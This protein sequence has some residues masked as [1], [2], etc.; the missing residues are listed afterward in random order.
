MKYEARL[1][2]L[3]EVVH[4]AALDSAALKAIPEQLAQLVGGMSCIVLDQSASG[5]AEALAYNVFAAE[6]EQTYLSQF[7]ADDPWTLI[8]TRHGIG[9]AVS[10]DRHLPLQEFERTRIYNEFARP[11]RLEPT[12]C[13]SVVLPAP[14]GT[15]I[16]GIQRNRRQ[17][18][19]G[20]EHEAMLNRLLPHFSHLLELR[21]RLAGA[22]AR[23]RMAEH[24]FD[25]MADA[26]IAVGADCRIHF[27]N[28]AAIAMLKSADG[29][30]TRPGQRL[31]AEMGEDQTTLRDKV[32]AAAAGRGPSA[33]QLR[34]SSGAAPLRVMVS[35]L[36]SGVADMQ[37]AVA[38]LLIHDSADQPQGLAI[39]LTQMF[40]LSRA[41]AE[42]A[43]SVADGKTIRQISDER[44]VLSS[45]V[46]TQLKRAL[47]KT[48]AR[49]QAALAS[50]VA[51]LPRMRG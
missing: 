5:Q 38:L 21:R 49:K 9:S 39:L 42:V 25:H 13:L 6:H 45:T 47:G 26:V 36:G 29:L 40:G 22:E 17:G 19:F 48:G 18:A 27:A 51:S 4:R 43:L 16:I 34:R 50:L 28:V 44:G 10:S 3:L 24:M 35:P 15:G 30:R 14:S 41:E 11:N 12:H 46:Q 32:A 8:A 7:S 23:A 2:E 1:G 33:L 37:G 31:G 20:A